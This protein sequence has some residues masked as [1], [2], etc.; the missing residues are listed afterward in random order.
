MVDHG[1]EKNWGDFSNQQRFIL[2]FYKAKISKK[3]VSYH[4]T[5]ISDSLNVRS[6]Y[7]CQVKS[8]Y[9]SIDKNNL[10]KYDI[11]M[12]IYKGC[13]IDKTNL[14]MPLYDAFSGSK[15]EFNIKSIILVN[16]L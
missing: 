15:G 4:V 9:I 10:H 8:G 5:L 7:S 1:L 13:Y 2:S 3:D 14:Y 16:C 12:P 11:R 6:G